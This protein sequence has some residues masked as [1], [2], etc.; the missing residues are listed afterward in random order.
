MYS[1][2]FT[3]LGRDY[4]LELEREA[5]RR[6]ERSQARLFD[7]PAEGSGERMQRLVEAAEA[8]FAINNH[9]GCEQ[10]LCCEGGD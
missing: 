4:Q 6:A 10:Y 9:E 7:G 1:P 5:E 2:L 8:I 3:R